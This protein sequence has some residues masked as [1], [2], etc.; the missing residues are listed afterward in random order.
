[1][2]TKKIESS[3][4]NLYSLGDAAREWHIDESTLRKSISSGKLVVNDDVK[5][6]GKQWVVRK[7]SMERE[8]GLLE[9]SNSRNEYEDNKLRQIYFYES[10]CVYKYSKKNNNTVF[11]ASKIF[12]KM[13]IWG[14]IFDCYDY[15]HLGNIDDVIKDISKRINRE[16]IYK[17]CCEGIVSNEK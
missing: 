7:E 16:L 17:S 1:M 12:S 6:F 5:K 11:E 2:N 13:N 15:L 9:N 14:Y 8:Y 3:F 4:N 10:E